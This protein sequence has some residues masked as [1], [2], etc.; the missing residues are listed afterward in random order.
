MAPLVA[1][2][3]H[4]VAPDL[5]GYGASSKPQ[6]RDAYRIDHLVAD[7][8]ALFD[9]LGARRRL[10]VGHDWGAAIAWAFA[11]RRARP[12]DGLVIMNVPHPTIFREVMKRSWPQRRR[13]WYMAFFQLPWLPERLLLARGARGIGEMIRR[14]ARDP[15]AF[16]A[17]VLDSYRASALEPGAMTAMLNYY[18]ANIRVLSHATPAP[19]LDVPTLMIWGEEDD[20]LGLELTEG[21]GPLVADFTLERLPGVSHWVQQEAPDA[22]NDRLAAWLRAKGLA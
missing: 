14:T 6:G 7:A 20:A 4:V 15:R 22:V 18:R 21:Y 2:G 19:R 16:P 1:L 9:A 3:W 11:L 10:L 13:S 17:A 5:R 12:L 8:A